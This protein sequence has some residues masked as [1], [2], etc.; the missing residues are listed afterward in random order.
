MARDVLYQQSK[1]S[2]EEA[3][4][5]T[6]LNEDNLQGAKVPLLESRKACQI[7]HIAGTIGKD[8]ELRFK[9]LLFRA[10]RD[11]VFAYTQD[12]KEQPEDFYGRVVRSAVM[13]YSSKMVTMSETK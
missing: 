11:N 12:L 4:I 9:K 10:T 7:G 3:K 1:A 8:E 13:S 2:D 5:S 6:S